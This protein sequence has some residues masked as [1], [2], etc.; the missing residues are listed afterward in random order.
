MIERIPEIVSNHP[1][2]F[3]ALV[4]T[5][6]MIAFAEYQRFSRVATPVPPARATRLSNSEDA[7]FIDTRRKKDYDAGHLPN[8]RHVPSG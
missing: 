4:A 6:A 3:G 7:V 1:P 5:L 8:A 2:M